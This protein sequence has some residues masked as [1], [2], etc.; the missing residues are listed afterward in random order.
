RSRSGINRR[1][2][3]TLL[4]GAV[5]LARGDAHGA[6]ERFVDAQKISDAWIT[7]FELGRAL[8]ATGDDT[9][10]A[11][12]FELCLSRKGET[13]IDVYGDGPSLRML[14][15]TSYLLARALERSGRREAQ[16]VYA[17]LVATAPKGE[18]DLLLDDARKR[19]QAR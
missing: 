11:A 3:A 7:H 4:E 17:S 12:A 9:R 19:A 10:A 5:A 15:E 18:R 6:V 16:Q 13:A 8:L 2:Y 14:P 1:M